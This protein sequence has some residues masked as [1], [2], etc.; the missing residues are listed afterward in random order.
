[1][2]DEHF[3]VPAPSAAGTHSRSPSSARALPE[4][5]SELWELIREYV[6][7][8]TVDPIRGIGRYIAF[9]VAGAVFVGTGAVLLGVGILRLLQTETAEHL[10]G[11]LTWIP[12]AVVVAVLA[13]G[14]VVSLQAV[15][16]RGSADRAE[17]GGGAP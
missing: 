3:Q 6:R 4:L 12:Y 8:E 11:S 17:R 14:G 10:T 1:M 2:A 5:M 16:R 15:G 7:Q 13:A 9:G